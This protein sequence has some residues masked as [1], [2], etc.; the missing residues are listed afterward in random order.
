MKKQHRYRAALR[1][2]RFPA[3]TVLVLVQGILLLVLG[4]VILAA[5][6]FGLID[7]QIMDNQ[8]SVS[9]CFT[10]AGEWAIRG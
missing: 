9:A 6:P 1:I 5:W 8:I 10:A 4:P 2:A 3:R 7:V